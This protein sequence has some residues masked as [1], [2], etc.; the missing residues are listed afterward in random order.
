MLLWATYKRTSSIYY[1]NVHISYMDPSNHPRTE[2][3]K[4]LE[5]L[6]WISFS[7]MIREALVKNSLR[8]LH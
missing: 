4:V 5:F 7:P 3:R 1:A 2:N 6:L 8:S